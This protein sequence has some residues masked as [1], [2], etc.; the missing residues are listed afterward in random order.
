MA[1]PKEA[2]DARKMIEGAS[3]GT[4]DLFTRVLAIQTPPPGDLTGLGTEPF[5]TLIKGKL[6]LQIPRN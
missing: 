5:A 2:S 1:V 3:Y 4:F 6:Y